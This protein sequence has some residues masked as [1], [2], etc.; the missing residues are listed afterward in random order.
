MT[1]IQ[2]HPLA[3][4]FPLIE[5]A[6]FDAL[7]TSI[8]EHGQRDIIVLLDDMI[9][10]GRNRYRACLQAGIEPVT[11]PFEGKDPVEF[12][13]DTNLNRRHLDDTQ[14]AIAA[15]RLCNLANGQRA[16][17]KH[18]NE[19]GEIVPACYSTEMAAKRFNLN[20]HTV[21]AARKVLAEGTSQE[22]QACIEGKAAV[23]SIAKELRAK[24]NPKVKLEPPAKTKE[25]KES[26]RV[27]TQQMNAQIYT[28]AKDGI[29][30][31]A[32]LPNAA[33]VARIIGSRPQLIGRIGHKIPIALKW[34]QEFSKCMEP[35][36]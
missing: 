29:E 28:Q 2:F 8:K 30:L 35:R 12:V 31:L 27:A 3:E 13:L 17:L 15:A 20:R 1:E 11:M 19:A 14:R 34:L 18:K 9:L 32:G 23:T 6:E 16:D 25:K 33:E 5:G 22:I 21:S 7:V 26:T 4:L 24:D 10:D 36:Q